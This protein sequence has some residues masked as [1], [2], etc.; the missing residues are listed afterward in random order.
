MDGST[1]RIN[2]ST[3]SPSP[4][5][6]RASGGGGASSAQLKG[7]ELLDRAGVLGGKG[8]S[9]AKGLFAKAKARARGSGGG[10]DR[11]SCE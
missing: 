2:S 5:Y 4:N 7:K 10:A 11:V 1:T 8:V 6:Q 9:G 3:A